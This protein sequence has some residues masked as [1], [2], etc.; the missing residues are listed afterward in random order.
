[1]SYDSSVADMLCHKYKH[2][3]YYNVVSHQE[4]S[5]NFRLPSTD[6]IILYIYFPQK[7]ESRFENNKTDFQ[8]NFQ[9]SAYNFLVTRYYEK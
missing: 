1:M 9:G 8:S 5:N 3:Y 2:T 7:I 6:E 4:K